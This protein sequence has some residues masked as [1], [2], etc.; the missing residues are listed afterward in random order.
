MKRHLAVVVACLAIAGCGDGENSTEAG[1]TIDVFGPYRDA[2]A[3]NFAASLQ[4][5]EDDTGLTVRYTGSA[6]F[7]KDLRQRVGSEI[8]APDIAIVPQPGV[9]DELV[10]ADR[11]VPFDD[12]SVQTLRDNYPAELVE[13]STTDGEILSA[14]SRESIKSL[15]WYRPSVFD[16]HGW[17]VPTTLDELTALVVQIQQEMSDGS[18]IAPWCFA[19]QSGSATG[20]T[21]TDWVEDL[22]LRIGGSDA[23]DEWAAG[24]RGFDDPVIREALTTFDELV[25]SKGHTAGGLRNI[26]QTEVSRASGPLFGNDPG[27]AMYKQ[28]SFAESW[29]PDDTAVGT[30]VDF[31]VLPGIDADTPAPL[32]AGGDSLVQ[33]S[34]DPD[35]HRLMAY[36]LSPQGS[37]VWARRG[38]YYSALDTVDLDTY[39]TPTDRRFAGLFRDGREFRF[40]AS[41]LMPSD[42]GSGLLWREITSWIAGTTTIDQFVATMDAAY[43]DAD[44]P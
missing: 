12:T 19:M 33:F 18:P 27:C 13:R 34:D 23:Y 5:F 4:E 17:A 22:V 14:P 21:A 44:Q 1:R 43:S 10:A 8:S 15:V 25:L 35:V 16:D 30:D 24:R 41:D 37:E 11:L 2:E 38:G 26:L 31:F 42:I 28:A 40:D 3:D 32:V 36:L 7:V 39:Y 9:V 29:F 20:W 6:D